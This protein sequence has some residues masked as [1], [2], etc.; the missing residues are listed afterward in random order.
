M[1]NFKASLDKY[2]TQEPSDYLFD[3][4]CEKVIDLF[5]NDFYDQNEDWLIESDTCNDLM[6]KLFDRDKEPKQA[7]LIIQRLFKLYKL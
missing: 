4:W 2:L 1:Q 3:N 7:V 6:N 5:D